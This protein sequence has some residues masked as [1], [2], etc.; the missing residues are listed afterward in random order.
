MYLESSLAIEHPITPA[1]MMIIS[2]SDSGKASSG[3]SNL[4]IVLPELSQSASDE[5]EEEEEE[6]EDEVEGWSPALPPLT[7]LGQVTHAF[8][9]EEESLPLEE[10]HDL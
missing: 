3:S 7:R 9:Q 2:Y 1:P 10:L 6:E 5:E 8:S 4:G